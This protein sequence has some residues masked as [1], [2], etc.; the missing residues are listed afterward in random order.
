MGLEIAAKE[1][2]R[3]VYLCRRYVVRCVA[4]ER[5]LNSAVKCY[6]FRVQAIG[7]ICYRTILNVNYIDKDEDLNIEEEKDKNV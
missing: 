5:F 1:L 3:W 6:S 2:V 7:C 4:S